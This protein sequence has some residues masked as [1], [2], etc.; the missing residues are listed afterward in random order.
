MRG[1]LKPVSVLKK[2]RAL[3]R[4]PQPK[5]KDMAYYTDFR[6]RGYLSPEVQLKKQKKKLGFTQ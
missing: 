6:N 4:R 1:K 3:P 2:G 5:P